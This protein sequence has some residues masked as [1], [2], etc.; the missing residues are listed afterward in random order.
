MGETT[1][2]EDAVNSATLK[3]N[4][5]K[6]RGLPVIDEKVCQSKKF[7]SSPHIG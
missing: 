5:T 4:Y 2:V 7:A 1:I 6:L 3:K